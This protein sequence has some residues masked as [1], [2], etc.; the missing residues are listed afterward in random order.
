MKR[1]L[2]AE[3]REAYE[4]TGLKP[5]RGSMYRIAPHQDPCGCAVAALFLAAHFDVLM[6]LQGD[7]EVRFI[8]GAH[9]WH[10]E[11]YGT[12]YA[13]GF[14]GGFDGFPSPERD[15]FISQVAEEVAQWRQGFADGSAARV[16]MGL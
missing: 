12:Y 13:G 1:I 9:A 15:G 14:L 16:E 6:K 7:Q 5:A 2:P 11:T 3:V 10:R 8:P 4:V